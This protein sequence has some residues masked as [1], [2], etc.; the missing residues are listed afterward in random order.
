M[1]NAKHVEGWYNRAKEMYEDD[2]SIMRSIVA[3]LVL[4][5]V[6]TLVIF[7]LV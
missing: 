3:W 7:W 2:A 6:A 1:V 5:V 4:I